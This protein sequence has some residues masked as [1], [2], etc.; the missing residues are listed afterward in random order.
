MPNSTIT[1]SKVGKQSGQ[2]FAHTT[3]YQVPAMFA[4]RNRSRRE[5]AEFVMETGKGKDEIAIVSDLLGSGKT[6]LVELALSETQGIESNPDIL[7]CG[8]IDDDDLDDS[9]GQGLCIIDEWDIKASPKTLNRGIAQI[10]LFKEK[11]PDKPL[12]IIGDRTLKGGLLRSNLQEKFTLT[13]ISMEVLN[14]S[15]FELALGNRKMSQF[16]DEHKDTIII[17]DQLKA[18]LV[19]DWGPDTVAVFREVLRGLKE[20]AD[21]LPTNDAACMIGGAEARKWIAK[22]SLDDMP[23]NIKTFYNRFLEHL[24]GSDLTQIQ[25][26]ESSDMAN[27][28]ASGGSKEKVVEDY[29]VPLCRAGILGATGIPTF[30]DDLSDYDR[31]PGPYLPSPRTMV[32]ATYSIGL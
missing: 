7:I 12:I 18:A 6:F 31:Y 22:E 25:P 32:R 30:S 9:A 13:D 15:F 11:Y 21:E 28:I 20:M 5:L 2:I 8:D 27:F 1:N 14:P 26:F 29:L 23:D 3:D 16:G 4:N 17:E 24:I 19:P 10:S